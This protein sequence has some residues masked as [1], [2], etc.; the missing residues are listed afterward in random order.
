MSN[1]TWFAIGA[2]VLSVIDYSMFHL[3]SK[4]WKWFKK[5]TRIQKVGLYSTIF[6]AL[7]ILNYVTS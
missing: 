4:R 6:I 3:E 1:I 5:R 2:I 7:L